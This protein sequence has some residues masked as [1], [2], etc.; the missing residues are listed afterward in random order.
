MLGTRQ[1]GAAIEGALRQ[2]VVDELKR[3]SVDTHGYTDF[4]MALA[5]LL[6]FELCPRLCH[7]KDRRLHVPNNI[8]GP[9]SLSGVV[10]RDVDTL[11]IDPQ[12]HNLVHLTAS[13][14]SGHASAVSVLNRFGDHVRGD[15]LYQAGRRL[16]QL[17]RSAFLCSYLSNRAYRR[18]IHRELALGESYHILQRALYRGG[19]T[20]VRGRRDEELNAISGALTLLTNIVLAWNTSQMDAIN[21]RW[22][23]EGR[24]ITTET[25][26]HIGPAHI[27]HINFRG[28]F[29]F[30]NVGTDERL[31]SNLTVN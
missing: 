28:T 3:V 8:I 26:R 24:D 10:R 31:I 14:H 13:V 11:R 17:H 22:R 1:A 2:E 6:G 25:Q 23:I 29:N 18:E 16:G 30:E 9:P 12:W 20:A 7:L 15:P 27:R 5:A 21:R 4:A 19:I